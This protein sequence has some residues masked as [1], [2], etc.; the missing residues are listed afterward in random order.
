[1]KYVAVYYSFYLDE[2]SLDNFSAFANVAK[3]W[4]LSRPFLWAR[5]HSTEIK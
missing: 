3:T 5:V 4:V 1:M 2:A